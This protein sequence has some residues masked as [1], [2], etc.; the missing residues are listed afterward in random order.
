MIKI[1]YQSLLIQ[2]LQPGTSQVYYYVG[3]L[4]GKNDIELLEKQKEGAG[5]SIVT[6]TVM[7]RS[8]AK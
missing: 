2:A 3:L 7:K 1:L 6:I 5:T 8:R 4:A